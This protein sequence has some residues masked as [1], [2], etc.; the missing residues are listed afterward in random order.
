MGWEKG[1]RYYTRSRRVRGNVVRQYVGSGALGRLEAENDER[2]RQQKHA[3]RRA[4][5]EERDRLRGLEEPLEELDTLRALV[6]G[7]VLQ[8]AGYHQHDRGEWRKPTWLRRTGSLRQGRE[9]S[10]GGSRN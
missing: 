2:R 10:G 4:W 7:A 1:G 3:E 9:Q 5:D 8:A 6:L